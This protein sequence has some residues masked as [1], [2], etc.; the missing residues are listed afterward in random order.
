MQKAEHGAKELLLELESWP[1]RTISLTPR[2]YTVVVRSVAAAYE[3]PLFSLSF[4]RYLIH[5][6]AYLF[7][8]A[9]CRDHPKVLEWG[10]APILAQ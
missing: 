8:T 1:G 4:P 10:R 7:S 3:G 5:L 6:A 2:R 9:S